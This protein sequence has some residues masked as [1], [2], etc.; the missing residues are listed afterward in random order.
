M[1]NRNDTE[2]R[3]SESVTL[4]SPTQVE[5]EQVFGFTVH[6]KQHP[7]PSDESVLLLFIVYHTNVAFCAKQA[8][9]EIQYI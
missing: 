4:N 8:V 6:C 1:L 2:M 7:E 3:K 5:K 9:I